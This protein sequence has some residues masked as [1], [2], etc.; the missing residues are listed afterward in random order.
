MLEGYS[1]A[2]IE[3]VCREAGLQ[4]IR[5]KMEDFETV[6]VQDFDFAF[7]KI[8]PSLTKDIIKQYDEIAEN[9]SKLRVKSDSTA[10]YT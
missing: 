5:R 3:N 4:A 9:L 8:R 2:D 6:E 10:F 1:G 7:S